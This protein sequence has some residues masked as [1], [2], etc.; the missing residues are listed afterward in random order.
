MSCYIVVFIILLIM[1]DLVSVPLVFLIPY[2]F[3]P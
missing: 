2:K 1:V 3:I